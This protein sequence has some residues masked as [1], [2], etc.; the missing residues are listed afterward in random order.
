MG[1][2]AAG[3]VVSLP[4]PFSDLTRSKVRPVLLVAQ[5]NMQDWIACQIT[6]NPFA[7]PSA[8]EL[9]KSSFGSGGL[10]HESYLLPGKL[11]TADESIVLG[12]LGHLSP[13]T[14]NR[15]RRA[16]VDLIWPA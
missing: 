7:N 10:H 4:F 15:V 12:S 2:F 3:Q 9:T 6:S 1:I 14:F 16:I 5:V 8:I 11:F 13:E